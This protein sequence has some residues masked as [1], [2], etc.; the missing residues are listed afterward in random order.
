MIAEY[1]RYYYKLRSAGVPR[2]EARRLA[3]EAFPWV[4]LL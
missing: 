2:R 4:G 3:A 1:L